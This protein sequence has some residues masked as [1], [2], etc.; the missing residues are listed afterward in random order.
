[1]FTGRFKDVFT[2]REIDLDLAAERYR[3]Y[4]D[5]EDVFQADPNYRDLTPGQI[6]FLERMMEQSDG[7]TIVRYAPPL[8]RRTLQPIFAELRPLDA[9]LTGSRRHNFVDSNGKFWDQ[10]SRPYEQLTRG[11]Q[12][13]VDRAEAIDDHQGVNNPEDHSHDNLARY[14]F[15][16]GLYHDVP[17]E[18]HDHD[19]MSVDRLATHLENHDHP[20][21][22]D[23]VHLKSVKDPNVNRAKRIDVHPSAV[24]RFADAR[25][26][27]FALE[28]CL[29]ADAILTE[30]LRTDECASVFSVPSVTLW[31]CKEFSQFLQ[32]YVK[33][34]TCFIIPDADWQDERKGGAIISQALYCRAAIE[35]VIGRGGTFIAAPP[36]YLDGVK[37][38]GIDDYLH[39]GGKL[40]DLKIVNPQAPEDMI[41]YGFKSPSTTSV[42]KRRDRAMLR[43]LSIHADTNGEYSAPLLTIARRVIRKGKDRDAVREALMNLVTAGAITSDKPLTTTN[44]Q[45]IPWPEHNPYGAEW[46]IKGWSVTHDQEDFWRDIPTLTVD[47]KY[48]AAP[49]SE[50]TVGEIVNTT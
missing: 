37:T 33:G 23:T 27:Y 21:G 20:D 31:D 34:R 30:I 12:K 42:G 15:P 1:M 48:R 35:D 10:H 8:N 38:K 17:W 40:H 7:I 44:T 41:F 28:G 36:M 43:F 2:D 29:K 14:L 16:P 3:S 32:Q 26:V 19:K 25:V 22:G 24:E 4:V 13:H 6:G 45:W 46:G 47:S 5:L 18:N 11:W 49:G 39:A 50:K 9:V